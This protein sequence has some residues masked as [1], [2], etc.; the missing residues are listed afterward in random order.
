MVTITDYQE[1]FVPKRN[2]KL[3]QVQK[4]L[5]SPTFQK[6]KY[7]YAIRVWRHMTPKSLPSY[8]QYTVRADSIGQLRL[9]LIK[10]LPWDK[11]IKHWPT[12]V[13]IYKNRKIDKY[14]HAGYLEP[15]LDDHSFFVWQYEDR[16]YDSKVNPR[17]GGV[18]KEKFEKDTAIPYNP[19]RS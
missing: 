7:A 10:N 17:T 18:T 3:V 19:R 12:S 5:K 2:P 11:N 6:G 1:E 15:C 13:L 14:N 16:N 8:Y 4:I 9:K